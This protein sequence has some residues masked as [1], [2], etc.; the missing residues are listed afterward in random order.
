MWISTSTF[1]KYFYTLYSFSH[2]SDE[3]K[4]H[5]EEHETQ[6]DQEP[7]LPEP[8]DHPG[9]RGPGPVPAG[10]LAG[11]HLLV[12][13]P[14]HALGV[15]PGVVL[16]A[17]GQNVGGGE[18]ALETVA[19]YHIDTTLSR[20]YLHGLPHDLGEPSHRQIVDQTHMVYG[21]EIIIPII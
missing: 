3:L 7:C 18:A 6:R 9:Q 15:P 2:R 11:G 4:N 14:L 21:E 12:P 10:Q 1:E 5:G 8:P 13:E 19:R 17:E 16:A 20:L